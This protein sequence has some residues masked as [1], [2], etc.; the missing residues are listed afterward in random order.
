MLCLLSKNNQFLVKSYPSWCFEI[1]RCKCSP[2]I[3][4]CPQPQEQQPQRFAFNDVL[5]SPQ[6]K[7]AYSQSAKKKKLV[8]HRKIPVA[9]VHRAPP[10]FGWFVLP[11]ILAQYN[12]A[13][14]LVN[15]EGVRKKNLVRFFFINNNVYPTP[16]QK[17]TIPF[18]FFL[19]IILTRYLGG[20]WWILLSIIL[21]RYREGVWRT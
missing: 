5:A 9:E 13:D 20:G 1:D 6:V 3:Q 10:D 17:N 2:V 7:K 15:Q 4:Y 18:T 16:P 8:T 11:I 12:V 14:F 19:Q 21:T